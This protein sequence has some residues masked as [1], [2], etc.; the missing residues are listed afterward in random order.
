[1]NGQCCCGKERG[2]KFL[3]DN[4]VN[5]NR[6]GDGNAL[7]CPDTAEQHDAAQTHQMLQHFC[8][9]G[10]FC[11]F[12]AIIISVNTGVEGAKGHGVGKQPQQLRAARFPDKFFRQQ[13]MKTEQ[14]KGHSQGQRD[15]K[16]HA[17][18]ENP[19]CSAAVAGGCFCGDKP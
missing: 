16:N 4:A 5:S 1:M 18:V 12:Q 9:G 14:Q 6:G 8:Y 7:F 3:Q 11:L 15:G 19:A 17:D 13:R 2:K 10:Y